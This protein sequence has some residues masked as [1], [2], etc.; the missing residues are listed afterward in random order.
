M[1][2][3]LDPL[4]GVLE[5]TPQASGSFTF[6]ISAFNGTPPAATEAVTLTVDSQPTPPVEPAPPVVTV[7][8]LSITASG[9]VSA[10]FPSQ[11]IGALGAFTPAQNI[12][13]GFS[14]SGGVAPYTWSASGLPAGFSFNGSTGAF[15]GTAGTA[16]AYSF[17]IQAVD[18]ESPAQT[19]SIGV[20]FT[21]LGITTPVLPLAS[22]TGPYSASL[23]ASGGP[24]SY[25]FSATGL[26]TGV[27][28]SSQGSFSG[29]PSSAGEYPITVTVSSGGLSTSSTLTLV[30]TGS[31]KPL[32]VSG[33][34]LPAG[35]V[36]AAYSSTGLSA[37]GGSPPY[38]WSVIGGALPVG[39][40]LSSSGDLAGTP[41]LSGS[42][43]FE[44]QVRDAAGATVTGSFGLAVN[45]SSVTLSTG[46]FPAGVVG[47]NYPTQILTTSASGGTAPY[48]FSVTSGNLP[49]GLAVG[50]QQITGLPTTA[51]TFNFT[52]TATDA[53][54]KATNA[55]ATIVINPAQT[56]LIL[57]ES[58][59][60]FAVTAGANGVPAPAQI[61]VSS[62]TPSTVL[63]YSVFVAPGAP[64]PSWLDVSGGANT[65]GAI[66]I[67]VDPSATSLPASPTPYTTTILVSCPIISACPETEETITVNLTVS[68]PPPQLTLSDS[69]L[70]FSAFSSNPASSSQFLGLRN[71]G[72]GVITINSITTG[73]SWLSVSG[74]PASVTAG[75]GATVTVTANPL[76]LSSGYFTS[77]LTVNSS[78]GV[79]E[80]PVTLLIT[81]NVSMTLGPAGTQFSAPGGSSPGNPNGTFS[82]DVTGVG[83]V[84]W[85]ASLLPGANWLSLN[86]STGNS[87]AVSAAS[88]T[89]SLN[90]SVIASLA[91]AV[92]YATIDVSAPGVPDQQYQVVLEITP[93]TA[94]AYPVLDPAGL[95]FE[96]GAKQSHSVSVY[97]SSASL[98]DYQ[99]S[100]STTDGANWLSVSPTTGQVSSGSPGQSAVSVNAAGLA[101]GSYTGMVSYAFSSEVR[102]VNVT[103]VVTA[104]G[105]VATFRAAHPGTTPEAAAAA[106]CTPSQLVGTQTGLNNNFAQPAGWPTPLAV[107]LMDDCGAPVNGASMTTT[108]SNGDPP[109][110][111]SPLDSSSGVYLGT[112]TPRNPAPQVTV[113]ATARF[114]PFAAATSR[115]T[116]QVRTNTAPILTPN[117]ILDAFNPVVGAALAPGMV[118][119]IYGSYLATQTIVASTASLPTAL[120]GTSVLIGGIPAPLYFVSPGQIDA[121]IPFE[122]AAGSQYQILVEVNGALSTPEPIQIIA[123]APGIANVGGQIV[124]QHAFDGSYVTPTSPAQPGEYVVFYLSGLGAT[125]NPVPSGT[126]TPNSPSSSPLMAPTLTFAG[127]STPIAFAGLVP[128]EIG[129]FRINFQ[130]PANAASGNATLS[131]TSGTATSNQ[132]AI[133]VQ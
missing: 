109:M 130:I 85:A 97:S 23:T 40:S 35:V 6:T 78:A 53:N 133:P 62:S 59:V 122:L 54:G 55:A 108:F 16:G 36:S 51:G 125:D 103:L 132:V 70:S 76:G 104:A 111:L 7:A 19:A 84:S 129:L 38:T 118:V 17:T 25:S 100:A 43:Q 15:S 98:I 5:G 127:A 75:P 105:A 45:P 56:T 8:P 13:G 96:T 102:S 18:A 20:S 113:T 65:P 126:P 37:T 117:A 64:T 107:N 66:T 123:A 67:T 95:V 74:A 28:L 47:V 93:V 32:A 119:E 71:A 87:S 89:Y 11:D 21:V 42:Y 80:I 86:A 128:S 52:I 106:S 57:S 81:Q 110:A 82:V 24:G 101:H 121:Q 49:P 120:A 77:T 94:A 114:S 83:T 46:T 26:P 30:V 44:A 12:A 10:T 34:Q 79:V 50:N 92:Y 31:T 48:I 22:T 39:M 14:A 60:S 112:W 116:G 4:T 9:A 131:V 124:A 115:V 68:A 72:G 2:L 1:G 33:G 3:N 63:G 69:I 29:V 58:S 99:A 90:S 91:P 61:T 88:A 27:S 41:T 73:D